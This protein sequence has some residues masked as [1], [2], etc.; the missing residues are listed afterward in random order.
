MV[1]G[2]QTGKVGEKDEDRDIA[3]IGKSTQW[4][5]LHRHC[6]KTQLERYN[7][8]T[9]SALTHT[10]LAEQLPCCNYWCNSVNNYFY[11]VNLFT[12]KSRRLSV[13]ESDSTPHVIPRKNVK[14]KTATKITVPD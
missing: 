6:G 9:R 1:W 13:G 2:Q 12:V 3:L 4:C 11:T 14:V 10:Q 5:I 7:T 8:A